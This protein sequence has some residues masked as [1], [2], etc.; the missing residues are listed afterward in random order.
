MGKKRVAANTRG[1]VIPI[2]MDA[3]FFFE[4]AVESLD[5]YHYEKALKYFRRAVEYDKADPLYH[6]NLAGVLSEMGQFEE[7]NQVLRELIEEIDPTLIECYYYMANNFAHMERFDQAEEALVYYLENDPKGIFLEESEEMME[8]LSYELE[9]PAPLRQIKAREGQFEHDQA[10][11]LLEEGRFVE[12]TKVLEELVET[13]AD[14]LAARN[15]LALAYYYMGYF[16]KAVKTIQEVL[17]L[18]PGNLHAMCNLAI[19]YK[20]LGQ[21]P[22]LQQLIAVLTKTVPMLLDHMFKLATTMGI[23]GEHAT[24]Y[25]LFRRLL[26]FGEGSADPGLYHYTAVAACNLGRLAE[27]ERLWKQAEKLDPSSDVAPFY[28]RELKT[29]RLDP[30]KTRLHYH[31]HLPF[32]EHFR[33]LAKSKQGIPEQLKEDPL[34]RSSFLWAL[35]HGDQ[36]T[37]LNVIQAMGLIGDRDVKEALLDYVLE[38]EEDDYL[39]RIALF[40][41]R[42]IGVREPIDACLG[43]HVQKID[44]LPLGGGL[45]KWEAK[46]QAVIELCHKQM[47]KRYDLIQQHDLETLW[48]EFLTRKYPEVP[49]IT[50]VEGWSAALEY[51]IAK[52]HRRAI[53]YQEVAARYQTSVS[54]VSKHVKLIDEVCGL[55]EKMEAILPKFWNK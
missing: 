9:R 20:H 14:F 34:V 23:L 54:T 4:R 25:A 3:T 45:P 1:N 15:N 39:K 36:E 27:A 48:L 55:K 10:R 31:Y 6:F 43:G 2:R 40:V 21:E 17:D 26:K 12:A 52:M 29:G 38:P 5:R 33:T 7:S 16:D 24:A 19:F 42:S 50:K 37:K 41:L 35:R 11:M 13:H 18:D 46:W 30:A 8:Y 47:F 49:R 32:E 44:D 28:L 22:E 51:L 53:S